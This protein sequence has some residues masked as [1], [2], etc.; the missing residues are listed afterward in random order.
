MPAALNAANEEAVEAF[1]NRR[2]RFLDIPRMIE[3]V[4]TRHRVVSKPTLRDL[5]ETD[6]WAREA[7]L[8]EVSKKRGNFS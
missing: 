8:I 5:L 7:M 6:L 3:K 4:M 2:I 1:L